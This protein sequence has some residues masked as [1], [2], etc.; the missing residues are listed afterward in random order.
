MFD[1]IALPMGSFLHFIYNTVAFGNYGLSIIIF[2]LFIKIILLPLN[3]KQYRSTSRMQEI[4]PLIQDLQKKYKNDKEKLQAETMKVYSENKVNPAGGCLPLLIQMPVLFSLYYV[5]SQPLKY[6]LKKTAEQ[7]TQLIDMVPVAER[8]SH[9]KDISIINYFNNNP[10]KLDNLGHLLRRDEL[11]N[12]NFFGNFNLGLIP[13]FDIKIIMA[14]TRYMLLLLIPILAAV[15]TYLSVKF[16]SANTAKTADNATANSMTNSMTMI[17]P[18]MTAFFAFSVPAGL[19]LY[20][21]TSNVIQI[22]QQMY[23]NKFVIK[24]KEVVNK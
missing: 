9:L 7:I 22:F 15:T 18:F 6:M 24:K 17:M 12:L 8:L 1:F 2:T 3:I 16:S 23:M 5:I 13:K 20:W 4:Q 21:I 11:I 10:E 14:D 19:G